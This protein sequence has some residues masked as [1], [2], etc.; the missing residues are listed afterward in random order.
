MVLGDKATEELAKLGSRSL[1]TAE[2]AGGWLD[3]VFGEG[4]RQVGD[5]FGE[6]MAGFRIRNRLRVLD[7]TQKAIEKAGLA[8]KSRPL[9]DRLTGPVLEAISDESDESLQEVWAAYLAFCVNPKNPSADRL[10][11]DVIRKLE[12]ADWPV[13]EKLFKEGSQRLIATDFE[14]EPAVLEI[15]MDRLASLGLF[16]YDDP[17]SAFIVDDRH[18]EGCIKVTINEADYYES[19]LFRRLKLETAGAWNDV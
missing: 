3:Q 13:L 14:I 5:A 17:R 7:K 16:I 2:K 11:V 12:P 18:Y 19:K 10:L 9:S 4:F 8:G 6:S 1:D 15:S